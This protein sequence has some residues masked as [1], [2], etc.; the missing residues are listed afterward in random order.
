[1]DVMAGPMPLARYAHALGRYQAGCRF[2]G[3]DLRKAFAFASVSAAWAT[4]RRDAGSGDAGP[5]HEDTIDA[6]SVLMTGDP[7]RDAVLLWLADNGAP[8]IA[9]AA[10]ILARMI[11]ATHRFSKDDRMLLDAARD[12]IAQPGTK[13]GPL[14]RC[15]AIE[16]GLDESLLRPLAV[17]AAAMD[18]LRDDAGF[19]EMAGTEARYAVPGGAIR[20][21]VAAEPGA[22][23]ALNL[24]T[25]AERS[26]VAGLPP[27][28]GLVSRGLFRSDVDAEQL[29]YDLGDGAAVAFGAAYDLFEQLQPDLIRGDRVLAHLS[30]NARARDA[31]LLIAAL[32]IVTRTQLSRALGLSRAGADIQAHALADAGLVTLGAGGRIV[33]QERRPPTTTPSSL[34][35]GPLG[36]TGAELDEAMAQVDRLLARMSEPKGS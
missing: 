6:M 17:I 15:L 7:R 3:N 13:S 8:S 14:S 9:E 36:Q 27:P 23:W 10:C 22:A 34:D 20:H 1:M 24:A 25:L 35:T 16:S 5:A 12:A 30:R 29:A 18:Q 28:P 26:L 2:A 31:W 4:F 32:R 19:L 21:Y 33:W 11:G